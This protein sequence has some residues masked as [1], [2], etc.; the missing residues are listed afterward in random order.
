MSPR[1]T[2]GHWPS[3]QKLEALEEGDTE[4]PAVLARTRQ[5]SL[6]H[7]I[8]LGAIVT[9]LVW[10][11]VLLFY[12]P[13][14][15]LAS[16]TLSAGLVEHKFEMLD[17]L[18]GEETIKRKDHTSDF[19]AIL[20][21]EN[22]RLLQSIAQ[23]TG[24]R[25]FQ[26][27]APDD[28]P[29]IYPA[30]FEPLR[31]QLALS[32]DC[33][34]LWISQSALCEEVKR[35]GHALASP[36]ATKIDVAW[37]WIDGEDQRMQAWRD[38]LQLIDV[39]TEDIERAR[40]LSDPATRPK[41]SLPDKINAQAKVGGLSPKHFRNHDELRYSI[42]STLEY[43]PQE[44]LD[45]L[46][47]IS[48]DIPTSAEH[49]PGRVMD[50]AQ[51]Q[52]DT[53]YP[54]AVQVPHWLQKAL[55]TQTEHG[56]STEAPE[57]RV[58]PLWDLFKVYMNN[59]TSPVAQNAAEVW[60]SRVLPA[61]N[62]MSIESQLA[63]L[64][65]GAESVF[66]VC[67]DFFNLRNLTAADVTSPLTGP[68]FRMQRGLGVT[69]RL[70]E[71][72]YDD[73]EGEWRSIN[74]AEGLLDRR[75]GKRLRP[76]VTHTGKSYNMA[77]LSEVDQIWPDQLRQS[78]ESR[79]RGRLMEV[80]MAFLATHY[81]V[82][83]HREALLWSFL[84]ARMDFDGDGVYSVHEQQDILDLLSPSALPR[85]G[86]MSQDELAVLY[87]IRG[88]AGLDQIYRDAHLPVP[89]GTSVRWNSQEGY[90]YTNFPMPN[91]K[92]G[93]PSTIWPHYGAFPTLA[94]SGKPPSLL[95]PACKL[96]LSTCFAPGFANGTNSIDANSVYRRMAYEQPNCG[97][98]LIVALT[99]SSGFRG[100]SAFLPARGHHFA[101]AGDRIAPR[102]F[103]S[104]VFDNITIAQ[105]DR[106][107]IIQEYGSL[108]HFCVRLIHRYSH[109]F[110]ETPTKFLR[111][112]GRSIRASLN[113]VLFSPSR[114]PTFLVIN[115]DMSG[116]SIEE[117]G[118]LIRD[119]MAKAWTV[120]TRFES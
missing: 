14:R 34:D 97:D 6:A 102:L 36:N 105:I 118:R 113:S 19:S 9:C 81:I 60:R 110:G 72:I 63:H 35:P 21:P 48:T 71:E 32:A 49:P 42:R 28:S 85:K 117:G 57:L 4:Q 22:A 54:R 2:T 52:L 88:E 100:L 83:K 24:W 101:S 77:L 44:Q 64:R 3:Y 59:L 112:Q 41:P 33:V 51:K 104:S 87:P 38:A 15:T 7:P 55:Y 12:D 94:S 114:I 50:L 78:A 13:L 74:Y 108:R 18:G 45:T 86:T 82:E 26:S 5:W 111:A 119:F 56:K 84:I 8:R 62:S 65:T 27:A 47:I 67:D 103:D 43:F 90:A 91:G 116:K 99:H 29:L 95:T 73:P 61:F 89:A 17:I 79:F 31:S 39:T 98:C 76:Y 10:L 68:L 106:Q 120:P 20:R 58:T 107:Q 92:T 93:S 109:S 115:D 30:D 1:G 37:V 53:S 66:Y 23:R 46:H 70:P 11:T 25:A 40:Y 96:S 69:G 80:N 16:Q 75:F